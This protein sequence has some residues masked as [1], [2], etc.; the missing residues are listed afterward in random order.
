MKVALIGATGFTGAALLE[1]LLNRGHEVRALVREPNKIKAK[2]NLDI[3]QADVTDE[4][5]TIASLKGVDA[6]I[7]AYNAGW[8]DPNIFEN[9]MK[10]S[11]SILKSTK[12]ANVKRLLVVGGAGSLYIAPDL[13]LIDSPEFPKEYYAGANGA[14]VL[15]DELRNETELDWTMISPPI[16]F[17]A[18]N[19]GIR[20]NKYR[21]GTDAPLMN[22]D[23]PGT[24]SVEDLA[25][26]LIDE[27]ETGNFI[28]NRFTVAY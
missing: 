24:I 7:S 1:E 12:Q 22:G 26:A 28:R 20:T 18:M 15:L 8:T 27:L 16:G 2:P 13:Q 23:Q 10:G 3:I 4:I 19:P 21:I 11:R 25:I 6:V 14:R 9:Y 17:S 5:T